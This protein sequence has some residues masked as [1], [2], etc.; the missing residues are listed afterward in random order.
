[1]VRQDGSCEAEQADM[2]HFVV[3]GGSDV[4]FVVSSAKAGPF[5]AAKAF[6][7]SSAIL[8]FICLVGLSCYYSVPLEITDSVSMEEKS[9][10]AE[11]EVTIPEGVRPGDK[12]PVRISP[13]ETVMLAIPDGVHPGDTVIFDVAGS[14]HEQAAVKSKST[15]STSPQPASKSSQTF[16]V[17]IPVTDQ[18]QV[19]ANIPGIGQVGLASPIRVLTADHLASF[20]IS[21]NFV[22]A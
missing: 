22:G 7:L 12:L 15:F 1:M 14:T 17:N 11:M 2:N 10:S 19:L 20:S 16:M 8:S 9:S 3:I 21:H 18:H 5:R 6:R 13:S 4:P